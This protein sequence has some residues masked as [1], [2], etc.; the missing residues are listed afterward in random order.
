MKRYIE[1]ACCG[2]RIYENEQFF[3]HEYGNKY[4]GPLCLCTHAFSGHF[5]VLNLTEARLEDDEFIEE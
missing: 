4:C 2:K 1:C 5:I 3:R